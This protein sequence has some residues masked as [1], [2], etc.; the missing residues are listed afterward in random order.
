MTTGIHDDDRSRRRDL[1]RPRWRGQP[2]RLE[3]WY[4]TLT[5]AGG[6]GAWVHHETVSP[7][8]RRSS[9]HE[10]VPPGDGTALTRGWVAAFQPGE[11]PILERFGPERAK[12]DR[13]RLRIPAPEGISVSE[14]SFAGAAGAITWDLT[15]TDSSAPL[16]TFPGWAWR[17]ELLPAA[18]V[19]PSPTATFSGTLTISGHEVRV[20]G[21]RGAV[22]HIYGHGNAQRWGWLHADLGHGDVLEVVSAVARSAG[23]RSLGPLTLLQLRVDGLDWPRD[24]L[25]AAP[26]F[27][28]RM[29]LP[30]WTVAGTVGS[31][32]LR[33]E[34]TI[35]EDRSVALGYTD[36]DGSPAT[37]TNSEIADA[38]ITLERRVSGMW[39]PGGHWKLAASAHAEIG[40]RP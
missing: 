24:P 1:L 21:A 28:S 27:R 17:H 7:P 38:E 15:C 8:R 35:P 13:A 40:R 9:S 20:D 11:A 4:A 23:L 19:V 26:L 36:P 39:R 14:T 37:C 30:T 32:R 10:G 2:G 29:G 34:V 25:V 6:V 12:P 22:A 18:Q 33:I 16:L 5:T 31:R 3:V